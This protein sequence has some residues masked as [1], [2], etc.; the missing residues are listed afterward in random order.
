MSDCCTVPAQS[1]TNSE[2]CCSTTQSSVALEVC[3]SCG[4]PGRHIDRIT[5]KALVAREG[6]IRL[7]DKEYKFCPTDTCRVV[8]FASGSVFHTQDV[9]VPVWQKSDD[10]SVPVC[11]CFGHS[12]ISLRANASMG[13][14]TNVLQEI[15]ELVRIG[16]CACEVRNPQGTCCLGNVS[17]VVARGHLSQHATR[18]KE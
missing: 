17:Q 12:E 14:R 5:L 2:S 11:Y 9:M 10:P 4:K 3:P 6:L 18:E 16:R 8:Y 1:D 15:K 7:E 13:A